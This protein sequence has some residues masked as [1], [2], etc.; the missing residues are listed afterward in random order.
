MRRGA[1]SSRI[2][3]RFSTEAETGPWLRNEVWIAPML[4][5]RCHAHLE[6]RCQSQPWWA[7]SASVS[8]RQAYCLGSSSSTSVS[9]LQQSFHLSSFL[10]SFLFLF[11]FVSGLLRG[12]DARIDGLSWASAS[13]TT[14]G[15]P[16]LSSSGKVRL[17]ALS[18]V[19]EV[20]YELHIQS[21][22]TPQIGPS[23]HLR[24][25]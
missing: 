11:L 15:L 10:S 21:H 22:D 7:E 18:R 14:V 1:E 8:Q 25:I 4:L 2:T 5:H 20:Y 3:R 19:C 13:W 16:E 9:A 24:S 12:K 17:I 6:Y 23:F